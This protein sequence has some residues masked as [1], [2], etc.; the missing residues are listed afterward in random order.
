MTIKK[1][2]GEPAPAAPDPPPPAAAPAQGEPAPSGGVSQGYVDEK[3]GAVQ[4]QLTH[5]QNA[6][7]ELA[8][9]KAVGAGA[10]SNAAGQPPAQPSGAPSGGAQAGASGS[11][12]ASPTTPQPER[13]PRSS[14]WYW[15]TVGKRLRGLPERGGAAAGRNL[16]AGGRAHRRGP[17][18]AAR[19]R[20]QAAGRPR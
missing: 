17:H 10:S 18:C 14:N 6:V 9:S 20:R 11:S 16:G 13:A 8:A 3:V 4:Q 2:G 12:G 15:A 7:S 19:P 1:T 5:L